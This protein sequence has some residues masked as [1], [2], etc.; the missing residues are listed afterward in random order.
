MERPSEIIEALAS[1]LAASADMDVSSQMVGSSGSGATVGWVRVEMDDPPLLALDMRI[2][3]S[4]DGGSW[5]V[6]RTWSREHCAREL[7]NGRCQ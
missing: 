6:A 2:E 5:V 4:R 1:S 7:V 3:M